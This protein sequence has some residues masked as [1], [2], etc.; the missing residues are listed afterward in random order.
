MDIRGTCD[1]FHETS[2]NNDT[3]FVSISSKRS[4]DIGA[5]LCRFVLVAMAMLEVALIREC[6]VITS[7]IEFYLRIV[8]KN[9][10]ILPLLWQVADEFPDFLGFANI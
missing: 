7:Q 4:A 10:D 8:D 6:G 5:S 9:I 2:V 1:A 3:K